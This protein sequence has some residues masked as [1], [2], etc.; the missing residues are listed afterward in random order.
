MCYFYLQQEP[1][2]LLIFYPRWLLDRPLFLQKRW[3]ITLPT[4]AR[5]PEVLE[6]PAKSLPFNRYA[7]DKFVN[8]GAKVIIEAALKAAAIYTNLPPGEATKF[9]AAFERST[10]KLN[11]KQE[12]IV[13]KRQILPA[14]L[15]KALLQPKLIYGKGRKRALT[16][17]ESAELQEAEELRKQRRQARELSKREETSILQQESQDQANEV[18]EWADLR[19]GYKSC[20]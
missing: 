12:E 17:L 18:V 6:S 8:R 14:H 4:S 9:A 5:N 19:N 11:Q 3:V 20:D 13:A 10:A 15:P 16:G 7:G 1:L 2:P